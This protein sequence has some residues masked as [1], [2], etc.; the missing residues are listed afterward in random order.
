MELAKTVRGTRISW[1]M[2]A[3]NSWP[4][5]LCNQRVA[6]VSTQTEATQT[7]RACEHHKNVDIQL[8]PVHRE[9]VGLVQ[10][11]LRRNV[12]RG[13]AERLCGLAALQV[14]LA[15]AKV[16]NLDVPEAD[17]VI[18]LQITGWNEMN[19]HHFHKLTD[20]CPAR[21]ENTEQG[22][23]QQRRTGSDAH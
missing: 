5:W 15:H 13:A 14:L 17:D 21:G 9:R 18:K 3:S 8:P 20:E 23:S 4:L 1:L 12:V 16:S 19:G 2:M 11:D 7:H 6:D 22:R 10:D